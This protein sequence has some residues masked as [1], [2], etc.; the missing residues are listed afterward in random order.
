MCDRCNKE[1]SLLQRG[2]HCAMY[3]LWRDTGNDSPGETGTYECPSCGG[4]TEYTVEENTATSADWANSINGSAISAP[5]TDTR[6]RFVVVRF[7][8]RKRLIFS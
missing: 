2:D 4:A 1:K 3:R 5:I 7:Y 6:M 8:L